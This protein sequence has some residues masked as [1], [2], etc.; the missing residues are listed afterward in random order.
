MGMGGEMGR[1][2]LTLE[3]VGEFEVGVV[4]GGFVEVEEALD[5]EGVVVCEG[6]CVASSFSVDSPQLLGRVIPELFL[7]EC[8]GSLSRISALL[9]FLGVDV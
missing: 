9:R 6:R 1:R 5:E 3:Y 8:D 4:E 7:D 2:A